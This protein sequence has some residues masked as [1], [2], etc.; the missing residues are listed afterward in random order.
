MTSQGMRRG[1][2]STLA[3]AAI[4]LGVLTGSVA[5][6]LATNAGTADASPLPTIKFLRGEV[7]AFQVAVRGT[8][9]TPG[10]SVW[11]GIAI[12][13]YNA[14]SGKY[15]WNYQWGAW[16]TAS[17]KGANRAGGV[18]QTTITVRS[19]CPRLGLSA[20]DWTTGAST[21]LAA[22]SEYGSGGIPPNQVDNTTTIS[23]AFCTR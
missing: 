11:I 21:P 10:G 14:T 15:K 1:L 18:V 2:G 17:P 8:G 9:Y 16:V 4:V 3:R 13:T 20:S 5:G 6:T 7:G 23:S 19:T 22:P 12:D